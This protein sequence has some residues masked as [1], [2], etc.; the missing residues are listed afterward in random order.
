VHFVAGVPVLNYHAAFAGSSLGETDVEEDWVVMMQPGATDM[1]IE[2]LC[3]FARRGCAMSGNPS[4]GG[5]PFLEMRG[6]ESDLKAVIEKSHGEV[7][8]VEVD[9][10]MHVIPDVR[11]DS[12]HDMWG[13]ERIGAQLRGNEGSGVTVFVLDTGVRTTHEDF[14]G[15]G[16]PTLDMTSNSP[17]ECDGDLGCAADNHGHGTHCAGTAVGTTFGVAP[18]ATVRSIKCMSDQGSGPSSWEYGALNWLATSSIRPAVA[19]LSFGG[20]GVYQGSKDA[21]DA[22]TAAGVTVVVAAGNWAMDACQYSPAFVPSAITVGSSDSEDRK[23]SFSS[24]G[25]CT[26]IWAPGGLITSAGHKSDTAHETWSGTSMATPHVAGGAALILKANP[27][28]NYAQVLERLHSDATTD[29]ITGLG[30]DD[31][32][33]LLYVGE[34][35]APPTPAPT[36]A[37]P[38]CPPMCQ[39]F[40]IKPTCEGCC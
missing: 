16:I 5:V 35:G 12:E 29:V 18:A 36:P 25:A 21:V 19:S 13:L 39:F 23:S 22:A 27:S 26:N 38:T 40:C 17:V 7:K 3:H 1:Q 6:T 14:G 28:F 31:T 4:R 24:Y 11:D 8:Y 20:K 10:M 34:G 32:N 2:D 30:A 15:R 9:E 37:P 33:L